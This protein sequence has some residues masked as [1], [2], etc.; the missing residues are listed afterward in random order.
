MVTIAT[1]FMHIRKSY[2]YIQY[3]LYSTA[4]LNFECGHTWT[5]Q[6]DLFS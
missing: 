3:I 6:L 1:V 4:H 2:L 5:I